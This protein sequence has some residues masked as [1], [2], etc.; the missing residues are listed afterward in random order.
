VFT[1]DG[2]RVVADKKLLEEFGG[3]SVDYLK[4]GWAEGFSIKP[5]RQQGTTCGSC[6]C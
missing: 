1:V 3:V 4:S 5:G 6:S 2:F